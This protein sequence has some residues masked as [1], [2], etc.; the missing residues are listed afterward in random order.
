MVFFV[1]LGFMFR[2]LGCWVFLSGCFFF[3]Y[4]FS[5]CFFG[6]VCAGL[7]FV[8]C[9]SRLVGRGMLLGARSGEYLPR[10]GRIV[11]EGR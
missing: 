11:R 4:C 10:G 9:G 5:A 8:T 3:L 1:S 7:V 6:F 2:F